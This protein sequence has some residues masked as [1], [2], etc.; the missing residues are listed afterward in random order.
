MLTEA[1]SK[2]WDGHVLAFLDKQYSTTPNFKAS[3]VSL[4]QKYL[5][6]VT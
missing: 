1:K 5:A 4:W 2:E 3:L 6:L